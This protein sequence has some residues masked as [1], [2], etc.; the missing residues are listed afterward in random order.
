MELAEWLS[1]AICRSCPTAQLPMLSHNANSSCTA[2]LA[3]DSKLN[4]DR[5][6]TSSGNF[7]WKISILASKRNRKGAGARKVQMLLHPPLDTS[8]L[9]TLIRKRGRLLGAMPSTRVVSGC[10]QAWDCQQTENFIGRSSRDRPQLKMTVQVSTLGVLLD[11]PALQVIQRLALHE[12]DYIK[13][14]KSVQ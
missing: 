4:P 14:S 9:S 1:V 5:W 10:H 3:G 8:T 7:S 11:L 13:Q 6:T 2:A 12:V